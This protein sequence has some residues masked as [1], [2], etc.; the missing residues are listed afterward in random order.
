MFPSDLCQL[1]LSPSR[2]DHFWHRPLILCSNKI[3]AFYSSSLSLSA[4]NTMQ[5]ESAEYKLILQ[6]AQEER[7]YSE[8]VETFSI[9]QLTS[10]QCN[11]HPATKQV[12]HCFYLMNR[13]SCGSLIR[14]YLCI[15]GCAFI[16]SLSLSLSLS[17]PL[18]LNV[19]HAAA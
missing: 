10:S 12:H 3:T 14:L 8:A 9:D 16:R 7:S 2:H 15:Y 6:K 18:L 19:N 11:L 1:L 5:P 13:L 4:I 17:L